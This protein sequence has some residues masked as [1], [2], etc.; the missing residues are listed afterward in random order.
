MRDDISGKDISLSEFK[1]KVAAGLRELHRYKIPEPDF[2]LAANF[3]EYKTLNS[4]FKI[5]IVHGT[6]FI[7]YTSC[8]TGYDIPLLPLWFDYENGEKSSY[9]ED[10]YCEY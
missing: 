10:G 5:P 6:P 1:N 9:F 3:F 8:K 4:I 7:M 2:F